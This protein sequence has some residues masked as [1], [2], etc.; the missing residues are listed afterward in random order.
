MKASLFF[1]AMLLVGCAQPKESTSI[2]GAAMGVRQQKA[3]GCE[4]HLK[5]QL[6]VDYVWE[7]PPQGD[8]LGQFIFKI[9][10][11]NLADGSPVLVDT[12]ADVGVTLTMPSM[13]G[14]GSSPVT[15]T[16]VDVGTFRASRVFFSMAGEWWIHIQLTS[17]G[18][19]QDEAIIPF[20]F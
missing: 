8:D 18:A 16:H 6:C 15:V 5:N 19:L 3:G 12:T 9:Y 17:G 13:G 11:A 14:H 2:Q 20:N 1:G 7:K 4:I 10:R